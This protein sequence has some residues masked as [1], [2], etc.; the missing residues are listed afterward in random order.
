MGKVVT[1]RKCVRIPRTVKLGIGVIP[2]KGILKN[3]LECLSALKRAAA[4]WQG[5]AEHLVCVTA[6]S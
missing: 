6:P 4:L 2:A 3:S 5:R 1:E